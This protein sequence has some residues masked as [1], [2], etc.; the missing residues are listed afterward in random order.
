MVTAQAYSLACM[1]NS[2]LNATH[3]DLSENQSSQIYRQGEVAGL[4]ERLSN[5]LRERA[6]KKERGKA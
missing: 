5:S 3:P 1:L 2:I 6:L 4:I